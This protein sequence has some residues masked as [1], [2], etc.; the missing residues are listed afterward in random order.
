M[1]WSQI[2]NKLFDLMDNID[3][4]ILKYKT[5]LDQIICGK[6]LIINGF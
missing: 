2:E 6:K 3:E 1:D 4:R 5:N